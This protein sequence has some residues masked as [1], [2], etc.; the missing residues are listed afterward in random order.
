MVYQMKEVLMMKVVGGSVKGERNDEKKSCPFSKEGVRE[1]IW[2]RE[3]RCREDLLGG[4]GRVHLRRIF[5]DS[6]HG[7][8]LFFK[9][10]TRNTVEVHSVERENV[11]AMDV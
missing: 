10:E 2:T 4:E 1:R 8:R 6:I 7:V 11:R 3:E 5:S 9:G